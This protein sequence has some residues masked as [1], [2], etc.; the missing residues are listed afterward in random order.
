M[1]VCACVCECLCVGVCVS[2]CMYVYM[3]EFVYI[4]HVGMCLCVAMFVCMCSHPALLYPLS[5]FE[6]KGPNRSSPRPFQEFPEKNL[7]FVVLGRSLHRK[8]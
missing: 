5:L 6:F 4:L 3:C 1:Y 8:L 7:L 2:V